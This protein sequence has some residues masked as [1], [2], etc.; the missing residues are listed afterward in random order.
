MIYRFAVSIHARPEGVACGPDIDVQG[1][2]LGTLCMPLARRGDP[3]PVSFEQVVQRLE[4]FGFARMI[5][6]P[7]G[8]FVWSGEAISPG[9]SPNHSTI[10]PA[11][12]VERWQIDGMIYDRWGH[13]VYVEV[14]GTCPR[15]QMDE[16]LAVLGW[17]D[18]PLVFGLRQAG[19]FLDEGEFRRW[20]AAPGDRCV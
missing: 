9:E 17:P 18:V 20:A 8:S 13:V 11:N 1:L 4:G 7:D 12:P 14:H 16:L 10:A 5:I 19:V 2:R 6:E 3:L 15:E